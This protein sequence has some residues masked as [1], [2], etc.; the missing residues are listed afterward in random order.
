MIT[1]AEP[2]SAAARADASGL[3][4]LPGLDGLRAIAVMVVMA[5]H[6]F[7]RALPGGFIGVDIFF[8]ISGFL[9]TTL[10]V[11]D[12]TRQGT[13][14]LRRFWTRRARRLLPALFVL[15]LVCSSAT[16]LVGKDTGLS[17]GRQLLGALTFSSNWVAIGAGSSYFAHDAPELFR[18][19]WSLAVE[20]QFYVVWPFVVWL[21]ARFL[22]PRASALVCAGMAA[23]S[24]VLM[25]LLS[26][27]GDLTRVYFGTDTHS[28]G[29]MI[30]A[31]LA[32]A[33]I[34]RRRDPVTSLRAELR[35]PG[36]WT[37]A[38]ALVLLGLACLLLG[39]ADAVTYRGGLVAVSVLT[40]VV[41]WSVIAS[42]RLGR[43]LDVAPL[44]AI[45][46]RSY[47]LYLWHWPVFVLIAAAVPPSAG[48]SRVVVVGLGAAVASVGAAWLSYA[49]I[50]RPF[51]TG[52]LPMRWRPAGERR[53]WRVAVGLAAASVLAIT[54]AAAVAAAPHASQAE[55]AIQRGRDVLATPAPTDPSAPAPTSPAPTSAASSPSGTPAATTSIVGTDV[56]AVGDSVMLASAPEL[57][58]ALPGILIDAE[59]SRQPRTAPQL[60]A[61]LDAAGD[62][63][64][65]VVLALGTNGYWGAGTLDGVMQVIGPDRKL[66]LVTAYAPREWTESVNGGDAQL[67][68][69][70]PDQ[71]SVADWAAAAAARPDLLGPDGIHP[72]D[73]GGALYARTILAALPPSP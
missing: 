72:G 19:L 60:L 7:P 22:R 46:R 10:L 25:A 30:G 35:R 53:A 2:S 39:E 73:E 59:V 15:L 32:F 49:A 34:H 23:L 40:A 45:G 11:R 54:T 42:P 27:G 16:L 12:V 41:I 43:L 69:A 4:R 38:A 56:T 26:Q 33:L 31:C 66:V 65:V 50:E 18:N 58:A 67:A 8:V 3:R 57:A 61:D 29:L 64:R 70:H 36:L 68:A 55:Q 37:G 21:L 62:L 5:F 28:F 63:R 17:L 13:V 14:R 9:I 51:L 1:V 6:F 71:V 44:R 20:E 52:V 24:A 47:G 48:P